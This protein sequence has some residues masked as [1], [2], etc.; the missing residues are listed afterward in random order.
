MNIASMWAMS[1]KGFL[2]YLFKSKRRNGKFME[3]L[4][5]QKEKSVC[6]DSPSIWFHSVAGV[7][8]RTWR[9]VQVAQRHADIGSVTAAGSYF[10]YL[11][12]VIID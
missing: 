5:L 6:S 12:L 11:P 10:A 3:S 9:Q 8:F 2:V 1:K 4:V 7:L